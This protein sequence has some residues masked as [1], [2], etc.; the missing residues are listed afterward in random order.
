MAFHGSKLTLRR[1]NWKTEVLSENISTL[2][3]LHW[4]NLKTQQSPV[5]LDL[6]L[7]KPGLR[8][9]RLL[10]RSLSVS[11]KCFSRSHSHSNFSWTILSKGERCSE[12]N[13]MWSTN[14]FS[15]VHK[16]TKRRV[17][18]FRLRFE[19]SFWKPPF[20]WQIS[21]RGRPNCRNRAAFSNFSGLAWTGLNSLEWTEVINSLEW[22]EDINITWNEVD[23]NREK[24]DEMEKWS[25]QLYLQFKQLQILPPPPSPKKKH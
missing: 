13:S 8:K 15:D 11:L 14:P 7:R 17:F 19:E 16:K 9:T 23:L 12:V 22:T 21:L 5:V 18:I 25:S 24:T 20:P 10:R 2:S 4:M 6:L 1:S 3:T